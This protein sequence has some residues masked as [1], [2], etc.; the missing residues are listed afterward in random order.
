METDTNGTEANNGNENE[1]DDLLHRLGISNIEEGLLDGEPPEPV[2]RE[3]L[4]AFIQNEIAPLER[5]AVDHLVTNY[6]VW[7][8]AYLALLDE[9]DQAKP[10]EKTVK[11]DED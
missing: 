8:E 3:R 5:G 1:T 2:D 7:Y 4:V 11:E 10:D 9:L 6:R